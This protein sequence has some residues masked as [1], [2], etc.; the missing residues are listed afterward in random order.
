MNIR[1]QQQ[2]PTIGDLEKNFSLIEKAIVSAESAGIDL[3]LFPELATCGYP[4]LDLLRHQ[5]FLDEVYAM[6]RAVADLVSETTV[7]MGSI[8][9]NTGAMG[10]TC[11]NS[12]L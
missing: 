1:I 6:N 3:L 9:P 12:A 5:T 4:P 7:I 8:T 10:R 11:F 2:N